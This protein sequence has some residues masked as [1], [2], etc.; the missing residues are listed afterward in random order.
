MKLYTV[1]DD[2]IEFLHSFDEMVLINKKQKR[3]YVGVVLEVDNVNFFIPLTSPKA[4]HLKMRDS[5]DFMKLENGSLGALN[6]NNMIPVSDVN[7]NDIQFSK[8]KDTYD[9]LLENQM[10]FINSH[11]NK[12]HKKAKILYN[13]VSNSKK[14][15]VQIVQ[16]C[17]NFKLLA[18]KCKEYEVKSLN[19]ASEDLEMFCNISI[20]AE[21]DNSNDR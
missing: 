11:A 6:L 5:I 9:L 13:Y 15:S 3:P 16:R 10:N 1:N 14:P 19:V 2:Y 18:E 21:K 8:H 12:I 17:V 4:K 20:S 7:L